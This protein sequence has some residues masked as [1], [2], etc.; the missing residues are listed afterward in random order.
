LNDRFDDPLI[1]P[2]VAK[3]QEGTPVGRRIWITA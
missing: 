1:D 3:L 2:L